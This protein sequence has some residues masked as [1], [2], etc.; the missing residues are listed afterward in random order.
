MWGGPLLAQ[1]NQNYTVSILNRNARVQADGKWRVEGVPAGATVRARATCIDGG[2]TR[3]GETGLVS[4]VPDQGNAFDAS[5]TLGTTTP[6]ANTLSLTAPL[7]TLN[8]PNATMQLTVT[9]NYPSGPPSGDPV[10]GESCCDQDCAGFTVA[11]APL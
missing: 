6:I 3:T 11:K 7:T 4:I 2:V 10:H 1:L 5:I 8:A 9:A